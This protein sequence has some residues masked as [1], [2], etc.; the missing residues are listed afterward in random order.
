MVECPQVTQNDFFGVPYIKYSFITLF[1]SQFLFG[2]IESTDK[3]VSFKPQS[4]EDIVQDS[5]ENLDS[6]VFKY[7]AKNANESIKYAKQAVKV[8]QT[9]NTPAS[10]AKA[11][12]ILGNAYSVT[13]IDSALRFSIPINDFSTMSNSLNSLGGFYYNIGEKVVARIMF[14]SAFA[15]AKRKLLTLQMGS[16]LG[17]LA[18]FET[19]PKKSVTMMRQAISY[20]EKSNGSDEQIAQ[21]LINIG[22]RV[23]DPD[24]ALHFYNQAVNMI[25][26]E[27]SP[28]VTIAAYNNMAYC[29]L[30]NGDLK[31]AEKCI[32]E[33]ALKVAIK[34]N[35]I[36]WKSTVYD[37]Y[38]DILQRKGN[39]TEAMVYA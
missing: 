5:L 28:V 21:S 36:D 24:S 13:I 30:E 18:R 38:A 7:I 8:A 23:S 15:I 12:K 9:V 20:L 34:T 14:D 26:A 25:S 32:L 31:N 3:T 6:L 33:Q 39:S 10:R 29:Y 2:C 37:T 35:N 16:S 22:Y 4:K 1:L 17:N 27:Y 19:D 11:Y